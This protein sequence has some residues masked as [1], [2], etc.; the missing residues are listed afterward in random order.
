[1]FIAPNAPQWAE[2]ALR[3]PLAVARDRNAIAKDA[4]ATLAAKDPTARIVE[5]DLGNRDIQG[6]V[7]ATSALHAA[8]A[9]SATSFTIIDRR[10]L[11]VARSKAQEV[12]SELRPEVVDAYCDLR[13]VDDNCRTIAVHHMSPLVRPARSYAC[14][15]QL[16]VAVG[17]AGA[18]STL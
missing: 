7:I 14:V 17:D 5:Q 2:E 9:T 11:D 16:A 8:I 13:S 18:R 10:A 3:A 1:V 6:E 12:A 4:T 15:L